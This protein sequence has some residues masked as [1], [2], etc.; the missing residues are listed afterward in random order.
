MKWIFSALTTCLE[1][2]KCDLDNWTGHAH[3]GHTKVN[4]FWFYQFLNRAWQGVSP[5]QT[6]C[7]YPIMQTFAENWVPTTILSGQCV[8][9]I[10]H[11]V[12]ILPMFHIWSINYQCFT[13]RQ[14]ITII[15][16]YMYIYVTSLEIKSLLLL[17][18]F[19]IW[20]VNYQ[21]FTSG[22]YITIIS[23]LDGKLP[24]FHIWS[25]YYHHFTSGQ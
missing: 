14:Y 8:T 24:M 19:H 10:S 17:L 11:L 9:I 12:S 16:Q 22:Q 23:H 7:F 25:I 15:Y 13:S 3:Q 20:S 18:L 2:L 4:K 5:H 6:S 21:C 1:K